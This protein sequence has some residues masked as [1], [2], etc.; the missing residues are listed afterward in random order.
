MSL[1]APPR[2]AHGRERPAFVAGRDLR[3]PDFDEDRVDELG[4]CVHERLHRFVRAESFDELGL[5]LL[6]LLAEGVGRI[7]R[8]GEPFRQVREPEPGRVAQDLG[9]GRVDVLVDGGHQL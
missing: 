2:T 3:A 5:G 7:L 1:A 8:G 4:A 9:V 6:Q